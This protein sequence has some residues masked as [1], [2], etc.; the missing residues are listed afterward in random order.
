M[1]CAHLKREMDYSPYLNEWL[2]SILNISETNEQ[3]I[4]HNDL[5]MQVLLNLASACMPGQDV[6]PRKTMINPQTSY[7]RLT[8]RAANDLKKT[9]SSSS[10]ISL[11][12]NT[13][14]KQGSDS[15]SFR[16]IPSINSLGKLQSEMLLNA[17]SMGTSFKLG[18]VPKYSRPS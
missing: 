9:A 16:S 18:S 5:A 12:S 3:I 17:S 13:P 8:A 14:T 7:A 15:Q 10:I 4:T 11:L 6:S 1:S 2:K